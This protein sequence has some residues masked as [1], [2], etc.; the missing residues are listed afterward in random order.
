[1]SLQIHQ[2]EVWARVDIDLPEHRVA[3]VNATRYPRKRQLLETNEAHEGK[4]TSD[5]APMTRKIRGWR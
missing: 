4:V 1:M 5:T 3:G 2:E